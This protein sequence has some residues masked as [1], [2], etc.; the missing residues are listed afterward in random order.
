[1]ILLG[2]LG[3]SE[4]ICG[5]TGS[6][7]DVAFLPFMG[8]TCTSGC[9]GVSMG[10]QRA[11]GGSLSVGGRL[12]VVNPHPLTR[13][14]GSKVPGVFSTLVLQGLYGFNQHLF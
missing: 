2:L 5:G 11:G 10:T 8:D 3:S 4:M 13:L 1:M 6:C 12:L 9:Q 14:L 7:V